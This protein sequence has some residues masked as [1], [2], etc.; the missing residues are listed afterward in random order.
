MD[1]D[2]WKEINDRLNSIQTSVDQTNKDLGNDRADLA[3]FST[4]LGNLENQM[5]EIWKIVNNLPERTRNAVA[6]A[7]KP[8][9]KEA[10]EL[11]EMIDSKKVLKIKVQIKHGWKFWKWFR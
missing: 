6:G 9:Q 7:V 4:K 3:G 10:R 5:A 2:Q 11:T 8:I 1:K